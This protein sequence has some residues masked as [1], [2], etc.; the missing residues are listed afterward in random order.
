M[1][2]KKKRTAARKAP[3]VRDAR[4]ALMEAYESLTP[5]ETD[6]IEIVSLLY[7]V[8]RTTSIFNVLKARGVRDENNRTAT[9]TSVGRALERLESLGLIKRTHNAAICTRSVVE[10]I[11]RRMV[12]AGRFEMTAPLVRAAVAH[13]EYWGQRSGYESY[14]HGI[15]NLRL[16]V[17]AQDL[18]SADVVMEN[19]IASKIMASTD[20]H[21][22]TAIV[23][24]PFDAR[25]LEQ[26]PQR[27]QAY[28]LN[29][30]LQDCASFGRDPEPVLD[31]L[32]AQRND[33]DPELKLTVLFS[34]AG[35]TFL[36]GRFDDAFALLG[37][38]GGVYDTLLRARR[39][40]LEGAY[41]E[42]IEIYESC[43]VIF[44]KMTGKR[45]P[46]FPTPDWIYFILALLGAGEAHWPR[47]AEL[48]R[49]GTTDK[50]FHYSA[51]CGDLETLIDVESGT[52][53]V[54][55][56]YR[57]LQYVPL[58]EGGR[59]LLSQLFFL[60]VNH[61]LG[62][63]FAEHDGK[64]IKALCDQVRRNGYSWL[65]AEFTEL[66][67][68]AGFGTG[69]DQER[70]AT[71]RASMKVTSLVSVIHPQEAWERTLKALARVEK[72]V[73]DAAD[74]KAK[75]ARLAWFLSE[76]RGY[77]DVRPKEQKR[78]AKGGWSKGRNI[79]LQR[80]YEEGEGLG[81]LSGQD[82]R[83]CGHIKF[84]Y[85]SG[86]YWG[87]SDATY[88]L[89]YETLAALVGHP[90]VFDADSGA[91]LE[92]VA[93]VPRLEVSKGG[94]G[95]KLNLNPPKPEGAD[96]FLERAGDTRI[97]VYEYTP[98]ICNVARILGEG[99]AVP[100][101][102]E[103]DV[104]KA[105]GHVSSLITVHSDIG[106]VDESIPKVDADATPLLQLLPSG[107]GLIVQLRVQPLKEG[108]PLFPPGDGG[109]AVIAEVNG[110]RMQT[111]RDFEAEKRMAND[112]IDRCPTLAT[113]SDW[114]GEWRLEDPED[115]L[116]FLMELEACTATVRIEWPRGQ[117][118]RIQGTA[119]LG[120]FRAKIQGGHNWFELS[121]DVTVDDDLVL[122]MQR[123]LE[124]TES[125]R[126]R[127]VALGDGQFVALTQAF[128]RKLDEL[129]GV[130]EVREDGLRMHALAAPVVDDLVAGA[131]SIKANKKWKEQVG[132]LQRARDLDPKIPSTL[133]ADLRD[134]QVDGFQWLARLAEWGVGACLADDMGLGKT[135]Q[136]L[137]LM[138]NRAAD[139]P[140]LV[141]AP[142]SVCNN[143]ETEAARFAPTLNVRQFGVG[144]REALLADL[145]SFDVVVSSYGLL[146]SENALFQ[147]VEWQTIVLDEAQ[148]IKNM[149]TKRSRAAMELNGAFRIVATGTPIENHLG[150]LWNLFRFINPGFL[151]SLER[152]NT[153]FAVPIEKHQDKDTRQHL[154]QLIQPFILRRLKADVLDELPARTDI[155]LHVELSKEEQAFYEAVRLKALQ[156]L[157]DVNTEPGRHHVRILAEIMRLRRACC[158]TQLID[159][160]STLPSAK[161]KVF[162]AVLDELIE[163]RHKALV[164][165]QFVG[166]LSIIR[167][168]L[169]EKAIAY[170]YLDG[171][172]PVKDRKRAVNAFQAGEGDLFL[173]S[174]KA[175]G[176]GL[177]LTAADYVIHMDPW[178]NPAVEDQASDRAH[179]IGQQRPVT[180]YRLVAR[181]TIEDQIVD[182][183]HQKRDLANSLL[184]GSDM[185]GKVS[186]DQLL[187][188]LR[189]G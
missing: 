5:F 157:S 55:T 143:W 131:A 110:A 93:G 59:S 82:L 38:D 165:S 43:L 74:G 116:E 2:Q 47:A 102:A 73:A 120:Q 54:L 111:E 112:V 162:E 118:F 119:G 171:S 187:A 83:A 75:K 11:T 16:S 36:Q 170:Q 35:I 169:D 164:F 166:H 21:P 10:L 129:R 7:M 156:Q 178:W 117:R 8:V 128:R 90:A 15:A 180:V 148:A 114:E 39:H 78:T 182:L 137:A 160:K 58:W 89:A 72:T 67:C 37:D 188:L 123:L 44:K 105:V 103:A 97:V 155:V 138:L 183:H 107:E 61:W 86:G 53:D 145:G 106:T 27:H 33:L 12:E 177:N 34:A 163:N 51:L 122:S 13:T 173:I 18:E 3:A 84:E 95:F 139:G 140:Q 181:G 167:K 91:N 56:E 70:A 132:R 126:S 24:N 92:L 40:T 189:G 108:G 65:E 42:A 50:T 81:F 174:L 20:E 14:D 19:L 41:G 151:G 94:K 77:W 22:F 154:K 99:V 127:F 141:V 176:T 153:R 158:N 186:A 150:E 136:I 100:A 175:G 28:Y 76:D 98:D 130:A 26:Q 147:K 66:L 185:A 60:L 101:R 1:S 30:L 146:Q 85:N 29:F 152:F 71:L 179:R 133:R 69:A 17:Y 4:T 168:R 80:L 134:Y 31:Y 6:V 57:V 68:Q 135:V 109:Q 142:T 32:R 184:E 172:T 52:A 9:G 49:W 115:C 104:L 124:L 79:S 125:S 45:K 159:E 63:E 113:E 64:K 121:G 46:K 144:D 25:W 62:R 149:A 23:N 161:L 48:V 88:Y 96:V 87:R